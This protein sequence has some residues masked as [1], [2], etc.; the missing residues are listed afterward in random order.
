MDLKDKKIAVI[1]T[2]YF[3]DSELTHPM[4][5]L[6]NAGAEVTV[7]SNKED[8]IVGEQ[9][10]AV[11]VDTMV[12]EAAADDYDALVIPGGVKNPDIMRMDKKAVKFV[13]DFFEQHKPVAAICHG[14]WLLVEA[15]VVKG[16]TL[17]SW[18]SLERD[19]TNAGGTR[20]DEEVVVD[21]G[22]I[23]SRKPDDLNAF[24]VKMVEIFA[25]GKTSAQAAM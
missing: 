18:P 16:R 21:D 4:E 7:I 8:E 17:T 1:A 5:A 10:T 24:C 20:V 22:L 9:G 2:D 6:I 14:P 19:I 13:K 15:D 3:E 23:T 11:H 25:G 12:D